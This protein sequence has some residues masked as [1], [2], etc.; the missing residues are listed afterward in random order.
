[1]DWSRRDVRLFAALPVLVALGVA[2]LALQAWV[3]GLSFIAICFFVAMLAV[4]SMVVTPRR[5]T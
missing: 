5:R 4:V 3:I 2:A 1:M